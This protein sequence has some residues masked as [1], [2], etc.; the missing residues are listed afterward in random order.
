MKKLES[1]LLNMLVV[2]TGVT[3]ISV[4]LLAWV[5]ELTKEPIEQAKAQ[6]LS[7][8]V[9]MVIPGFDNDPIKEKKVQKVNNVEYIVY[10]ATKSGV[11]IGAAVEASALGFG[12]ELKILVGFDV[13]GNIINYSL[14]SHSETP[15]LGSKADTWFKAGGK[16]DITGMNPGKSSLSVSKDGGEV[17][18]ITASTITSR[19]FLNAVNG[20]YAAFAGLEHTDAHTGKKKKKA[21][22]SDS[23]DIAADDQLNDQN[24]KE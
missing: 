15:G 14:L 9:G 20:A 6:A 16:G 19:A 1:T 23:K 12:G 21:E 17:D 11:S 8:A 5:N 4:A 24:R 18:A 3:V 2:L 13:E 7:D 10:P 22:S